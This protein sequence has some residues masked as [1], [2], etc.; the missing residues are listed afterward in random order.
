[1]MLTRLDTFS[2]E[3]IFLFLMFTASV[4][5]PR[6]QETAVL[7]GAQLKPCQYSNYF[8]ISASQLS[9]CVAIYSVQYMLQF[10][11]SVVECASGTD[12]KMFPL[13]RSTAFILSFE[14]FTKSL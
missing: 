7:R 8:Q 12:H 10:F 4:R 9:I 11:F 6:A 2:Q 5:I 1:M 13:C 14:L 3:Q